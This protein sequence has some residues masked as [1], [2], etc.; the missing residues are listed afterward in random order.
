MGFPPLISPVQVEFSRRAAASIRPA[1]A[2]RP[3]G[4]RQGVKSYIA[5]LP[6]YKQT[7]F[8]RLPDRPLS[9]GKPVSHPAQRFCSHPPTPSRTRKERANIRIRYRNPFK[10]INKQHFN[11]IKPL[12]AL[13]PSV[14]N[15]FFP[16]FGHGFEQGGCG[17]KPPFPPAPPYRTPP[18]PPAFHAEHGG[19]RNAAAQ[20]SKY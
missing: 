15:T 7:A 19:G 10:R 20:D 8:R 11:L 6:Y 5:T 1:Q 3:A 14:R 4:N 12:R 18:S 17:E 2:K 13:L 9:S 16:I